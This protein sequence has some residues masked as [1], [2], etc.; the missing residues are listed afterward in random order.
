MPPG[1]PPVPASGFPL[2]APVAALGLADA[3]LA[4]PVRRNL[5]GRATVYDGAE[6]R[7]TIV[8]PDRAAVTVVSLDLLSYEARRVVADAVVRGD[9]ITVVFDAVVFD[10]ASGGLRL[11]AV[12]VVAGDQAWR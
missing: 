1:P 2:G 4:P 11:P 6:Q 12:A 3:A 5:R 10:A 8:S 7:L 9:P